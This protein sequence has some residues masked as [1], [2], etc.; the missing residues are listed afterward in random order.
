MSDSL[1]EM[2]EVRLL[3]LP[4]YQEW[5]RPYREE[6]PE[7]FAYLDGLTTL[8]APDQL[9]GP[10]DELFRDLYEEVLGDFGLDRGDEAQFELDD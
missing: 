10:H 5:S 2:R 6:Y 9:S 1:P 7:A 3:D 4:G 8:V